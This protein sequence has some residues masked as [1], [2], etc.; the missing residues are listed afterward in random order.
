[1]F[2]IIINLISGL[3]I[4]AGCI[5]MIIGA[6]GLIR[7]PD[8]FTRVHAASITDTNATILIITGLTV[9]AVVVFDNPLTTLK[10][11]LLLFFTHFTYPTA[12][13]VLA[14]AAFK[15]GLQPLDKQQN[16]IPLS[17][18]ITQER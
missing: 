14:K 6:I 9:Q 7:M 16:P 11:I 4:L 5:S 17:K 2:E 3:L 1:M 8:F 10:L 18:K 13:H 12:S 15:K